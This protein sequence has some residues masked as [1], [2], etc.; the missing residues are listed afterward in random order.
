MYNPGD[1]TLVIERKDVVDTETEDEDD[2]ASSSSGKRYKGYC[3]GRLNPDLLLCKIFY[4]T[5]YGSYGSLYPLIAIYFKQLGLTATESGILVGIRPFVEFCAAPMWGA[6]ADTWRKAKFILLLSLVSWLVFTEAVAFIE[7][8]NTVC[9]MLNTTNPNITVVVD[10]TGVRITHVESVPKGHVEVVDISVKKRK[11]SNI[12]QDDV[13]F[14]NESF[15][16]RNEL[17][18]TD[19]NSVSTPPIK[20]KKPL[21]RTLTF[22]K[23]KYE[24]TKSVFILL[25]LFMIV[26]EFFSSPTITLADSATLGYLGHQRMELYGRQRMFG[27]LAWGLIMFLE[28]LI[29]ERTKI[30]SVECDGYAMQEKENY[31]TCF[32]TYAVLITCSFFIATQLSFTYQAAEKKKL[33]TYKDQSSDELILLQQL[34]TSRKRKETYTSKKKKQL[35]LENSDDGEPK[36][37]EVLGLY[38]SVKYGTVLYV[39][40]FAGFGFGFLFTFLYWHLKQLGGPPTLFG[41]ASIVNHSSEVTGYFFSSWL[42]RKMGHIPL[43]CLGLMCFAVRFIV[44]SWLVN[45]WWVLVV[46]SLQGLTHA[47]IW[48]ASTSYIGAATSQK[49]RSSAQGILQGVYHGL[50]RGCGA[51]FGGLII[52]SYGTVTAFRGIGV[53]YLVVVLIFAFVQ[54]MENNNDEK[55]KTDDEEDALSQVTQETD[56]TREDEGAT[57]R[58]EEDS[59]LD[60]SGTE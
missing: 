54:F 58:L 56:L 1:D 41:V 24:N 10:S 14:L 36:Y 8:G 28:G 23:Y 5:F 16:Q 55:D 50:G 27:S 7:P 34:N 45:P 26:G 46:E 33:P 37:S 25:L 29:L 53:S 57:S 13:S 39:V 32:G 9:V 2:D 19:E 52:S 49:N 22:I 30:V 21:D 44:I 17:F 12:R 47:A 43:I 11:Y 59:D 60:G 4:F 42:I 15:T 38:A 48:A 20:A 6:V 40:W 51:I 35:V 31:L 3:Y 18:T